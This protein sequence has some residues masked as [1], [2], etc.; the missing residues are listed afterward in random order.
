MLGPLGTVERIDIGISTVTL[1][2]VHLRAS[3]D[4]PVGDTFKAERNVLELDKRALLARRIRF[5]NV[6]VHDYY[7]AVER[8]NE[9]SSPARR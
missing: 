1:T 3:H 9:F 5:C 6:A 7:V 2:R 4:R 8:T